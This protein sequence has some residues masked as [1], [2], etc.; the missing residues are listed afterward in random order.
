MLRTLLQALLAGWLLWLAGPA[1]AGLPDVVAAMKPSV[2]AIGSYNALKSPRFNFHGTGFVVGNGTLVVTN[3]HV[4]PSGAQVDLDAK[5]MVLLPNAKASPGQDD[6]E[7]RAAS[8]VDTDPVHDLALLKL[9][10][11]PLPALTLG[12]SASVRDGQSV[13]LMGFP[14]GGVLGFR[15][16][17]HQ[18]IVSS[19]TL[20]AL[21]APTS[22]QLDERAVRQ[23][24][25]GPFELFQLDAIAYPGNSGGP[26]F[27][28]DSGAVLG[29]LNMGLLKGT[30]ESALSQPTGISYAIPVRFVAELL[31]RR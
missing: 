11:S 16:V 22:R 29:V 19:L 15:H 8:V 14:I 13:A 3:A 2:L 12:D 6:P 20:V 27:D 21:P 31:A 23:L 18:G 10:G 25:Q 26:V 24:R 4:L 7:L 30:R 9:E 17:T 1:W 5:L 28:P